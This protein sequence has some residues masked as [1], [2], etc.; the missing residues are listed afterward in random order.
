MSKNWFLTARLPALPVLVVAGLLAACG[1]GG[2]SAPSASPAVPTSGTVALA[3]DEQEARDL[4]ILAVDADDSAVGTQDNFTRISPVGSRTGPLLALQS[5]NV[6]RKIASESIGCSN[7]FDIGMPLGGSTLS[8]CSG[9][10]QITS[11]FDEYSSASAIPAGGYITTRFVGL[12]L[13]S[14]AGQTVGISGSFT[15]TVLTTLDLTGQGG[16]VGTFRL[17]AQNLSGVDEFGNVFGPES[18]SMDVTSNADGTASIV[19]DGVRVDNIDVT[20]TG[21]EDTFRINSGSVIVGYD[22]G[23]ADVTFNNWQVTDS[24]PQAGSVL[25]VEGA[26]GSATVSVVSATPTSA[27]F[28]VT[29]SSG[30]STGVHTVVASLSNG[31]FVI[32]N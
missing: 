9:S 23:Y 1:G 22:G 7:F 27:T 31:Q 2:G 4:V 11:N 14:A 30:G 19:Y 21:D 20:E 13:T 24:I 18:F 6:S 17:S 32:N 26:S 28:E 15:L 5:A 12:N 8:A 10:V 25:T 29:I 3:T 16:F